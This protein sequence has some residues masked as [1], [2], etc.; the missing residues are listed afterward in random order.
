RQRAADDELPIGLPA[1]E[2]LRGRRGP[3]EE[4]D[5][6]A[7]DRRRG[8][9]QGLSDEARRDRRIQAADRETGDRP[10]RG[11][12]EDAPRLRWDSGQLQ[13]HGGRVAASAIADEQQGGT[14]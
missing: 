1:K 9:V 8:Q 12:Q 6:A 13:G 5:D 11:G 14:G 2:Q 3:E 7:G 10:R 4:E